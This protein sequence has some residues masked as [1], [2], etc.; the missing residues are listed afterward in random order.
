MRP[1]HIRLTLV[2]LLALPALMAGVVGALGAKGGGGHV[3]IRVDSVACK[4]LENGTTIISVML[5]LPNPGYNITGVKYEVNNGTV[6]IYIKVEPPKKPVIQVIT[7]RGFSITVNGTVDYLR[8][9]VNSSKVYE[10]SCSGH[11]LGVENENATIGEQGVST[12][13]GSQNITTVQPTSIGMNR[14]NG[15][16]NI[17]EIST[18]TSKLTMLGVGIALALLGLALVVRH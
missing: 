2:I 9:Y 16:D 17:E 6:D 14:T 10:T 5:R 4:P 8:I 7:I 11:P 3:P 12:Q 18:S 1:R 13:G 15:A